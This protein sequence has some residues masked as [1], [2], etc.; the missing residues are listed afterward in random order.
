MTLTKRILLTGASGFL[1]QH[2]LKELVANSPPNNIKYEVTALFGGS[3]TE[4]ESNLVDLVEKADSSI[5]IHCQKLDLTSLQEITEWKNQLPAGDFDLC[6]HMAALS[7]PR[8]CQADP[9]K[10]Q[11]INVPKILFQALGKDTPIIALSTDQVYAGTPLQNG[12]T[13]FYTELES[14]EPINIYG[15]TKLQ[16]EEYL[17]ENFSAVVLLRSS[18]I[19]GPLAPLGGAHDTFLHFCASLEN[20][21]TTLFVNEYRNIISVN[22]VISTITWFLYN[23]SKKHAGIYNMGGALRLHR[24]DMAKA[25]FA[26]F[27][28]HDDNVLISAEQISPLSPL[29]ISMDSS[30]LQQVTG[31]QTVQSLDKLV[32]LTFGSKK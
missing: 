29:D 10:A 15:T 1:G 32:E 8:A 11:Q 21:E 5:I 23:P 14:A 3:N 19:V 18:I 2:L 28:Y 12:G 24:L 27:D 30:K 16:M 20:K 25:V 6:I 26:H 13:N 7:S 31:I 17:G 9:D 4:F 22:D